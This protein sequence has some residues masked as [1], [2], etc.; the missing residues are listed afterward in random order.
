MSMLKRLLGSLHKAVFDTSPDSAIAFFIR[1]PDGVTWSIADEKLVAT[2]NGFSKSYALDKLTVGQLAG[3][4]VL[5][6]FEV[7]GVSSEFAG[8]SASVLIEGSGNTLTSNG[9]RLYGFRDLLHSLFGAYARELQAA[10]EQIGE[11]IRQMVITQAEGEW[12]DLWGAL[13]NTPRPVGMD[14]AR[15]Q[16]LIPQEAF[17]LRVN[18]YA[19]EKAIRDLTG[20]PVQIE[21]PWT[22]IFRLDSSRLSSIH[23]FYDGDS[24]GY[25]IIRP[26]ADQPIVWDGIIDIIERNKAAGVIVLPPEERNRTFVRD[27]LAGI[28]WFQTWS[29]M[30]R[31]VQ[32]PNVPYLDNSLVLSDYEVDL[33]WRSGI[34]STMMLSSVGTEL[35]GNNAEPSA[36]HILGYGPV[37]YLGEIKAYPW[38]SGIFQP[39]GIDMYPQGKR[40][41]RTA[42]VWKSE[43]SWRLPYSWRV[44]SRMTSFSSTSFASAS[45]FGSVTSATDSGADWNTD[46]WDGM[47]WEGQAPTE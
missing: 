41:W 5:D 3:Q 18:G 22:D 40:T 46:N 23:R 10:K 37:V 2:V 26:V 25:H 19:I 35:N 29:K 36:S 33:N 44:I 13:Y 1:H 7:Q 14:D 27:P 20:Q 38:H 24:V 15:Y 43:Q 21:E 45:V 47:T 31:L 39:V 8:L 16:P 28:I 9:D 32:T 30:G 17:R 12:L 42:V 4:M 11:A 34:T 6:G